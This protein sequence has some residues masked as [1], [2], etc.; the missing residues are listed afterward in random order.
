[1]APQFV[2]P[3][4]K[5]NK[6]DARDAEAVSRPNMRFVGAALAANRPQNNSPLKRHPQYALLC[7]DRHVR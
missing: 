6:N 2:K 7:P 1:M 3:C 4:V 5:T